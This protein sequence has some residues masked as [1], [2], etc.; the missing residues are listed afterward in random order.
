MC[1]PSH[2]TWVLVHCTCC[3]TLHTAP[4]ADPIPACDVHWST[5]TKHFITLH[6]TS[7]TKSNFKEIV[8][9]MLHHT[10]LHSTVHP[11]ALSCIAHALCFSQ[12]QLWVVQILGRR[13]TW[14]VYCQ[15]F[16]TIQWLQIDRLEQGTHCKC[17]AMLG[18]SRSRA[19]IPETLQKWP[20][21][22]S[23]RF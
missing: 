23:A 6:D 21:W 19:Y 9:Q 2:C 14:L 1:T 13:D 10:S 20:P 15:C 18:F 4:V 7:C 11:I 17:N 5:A 8:L 22:W 12:C 3:T 16:P